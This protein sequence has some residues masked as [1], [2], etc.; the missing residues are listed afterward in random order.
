MY[1][2]EPLVV[3]G[4]G[5]GCG[6]V[7]LPTAG[8]TQLYPLYPQVYE[9]GTHVDAQQ[10]PSSYE[11]EATLFEESQKPSPAQLGLEQSDADWRVGRGVGLGVGCGVEHA[12]P[13]Q[14]QP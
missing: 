12:Q 11:H 3:V 6:F 7:G 9:A 4:R 14:S 13:E 2:K 5:V 8:S 1:T 10:S